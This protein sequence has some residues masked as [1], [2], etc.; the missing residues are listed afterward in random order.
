MHIASGVRLAVDT[1]GSMSRLD[2]IR[3]RAEQISH[4]EAVVAQLWAEQKADVVEAIREGE[5][6]KDV[7]AASGR[8]REWVRRLQRA[9]DSPAV[10]G[11]H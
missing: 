5:S 1:I 8:T 6:Q 9:S 11:V 10:D 3:K 7:V 2:D 4:A